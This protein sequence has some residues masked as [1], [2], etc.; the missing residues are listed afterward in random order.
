MQ[1][2]VQYF[3]LPRMSHRKG[4]LKDWVEMEK[5][6]R[7]ERLWRRS[8]KDDYKDFKSREDRDGHRRRG[9]KVE[10]SHKNSRMRQTT[11]ERGSS[12]WRGAG[13]V[14]DVPQDQAK[15][16]IGEWEK[17]RI[18]RRRNW[19][20]CSHLKRRGMSARRV[21]SGGPVSDFSEAKL[22]EKRVLLLKNLKDKENDKENQS[23]TAKAK[24]KRRESYCVRGSRERESQ[25]DSTRNHDQQDGAL[26]KDTDEEFEDML[27]RN[28]EYFEAAALPMDLEQDFDQGSQEGE[29]GSWNEILLGEKIVEHEEIENEESRDEEVLSSELQQEIDMESKPKTGLNETV[30]VH[31]SPEVEVMGDV[32]TTSEEEEEV[33]GAAKQHVENETRESVQEKVNEVA[34]QRMAK[35]VKMDRLKRDIKA[36]QVS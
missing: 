7:R 1:D 9:L 8:S 19:G 25:E 11:E 36:L 30:S 14:R 17:E 31:S 21:D 24:P 6:D 18:E 35:V 28:K 4:D 34:M 26:E 22:E 3:G 10:E 5:R 23:I 29:N 16:P 32:E 2:R 13:G 20:Q 33:N 27:K 12:S 15:K